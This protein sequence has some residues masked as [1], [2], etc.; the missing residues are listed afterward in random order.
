MNLFHTFNGRLLFIAIVIVACCCVQ[1][2]DVNKFI[3]KI[4]EENSSDYRIPKLQTASF[5]ALIF[6]IILLVLALFL[7]VDFE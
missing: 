4:N 2:Y 1:S 5:G 7:P 3:N 6:V